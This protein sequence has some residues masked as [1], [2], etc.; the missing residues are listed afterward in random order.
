MRGLRRQRF[1]MSCV[2]GQVYVLPITIHRIRQIV[3]LGLVGS[4]LWS[5]AWD[6]RLRFA[7]I[8]SIVCTSLSCHCLAWF[9]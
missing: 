5:G 9:K 3:R 6:S 2:G 4:V 1:S 8:V 7:S